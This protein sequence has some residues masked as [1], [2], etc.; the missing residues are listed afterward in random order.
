LISRLVGLILELVGFVGLLL[1][2][3]LVAFYSK[4]KRKVN[5]IFSS[6]II[7]AVL[8]ALAV[9]S[10]ITDDMPLGLFGVQVHNTAYELAI[11]LVSLF[12]GLP[13]LGGTLGVLTGT[14]L[15]LRGGKEI[16]TD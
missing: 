15:R 13:L 8:S 11:F 4:G 2:G 5:A 7:S 10:L 1:V 3:I 9:Y 14:W 16:A 12:A 6:L